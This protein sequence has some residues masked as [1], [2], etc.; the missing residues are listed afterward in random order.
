MAENDISKFRENGWIFLHGVLNTED[1]LLADQEIKN[2][3]KK[4]S[5]TTK[6]DYSKDY[7]NAF[8]N[9][10]DLAKKSSS[11]RDLVDKKIK[12]L[13]DRL[14]C[15]RQT[16]YVRDQFFNKA[17]ETRHTPLH[18]DAYSLPYYCNN[19]YTLWIPLVQVKSHPLLLLDRSHCHKKPHIRPEKDRQMKYSQSSTIGLKP[20]DVSVHDGWL[21][22][23]T[24]PNTVV[25]NQKRSAW[26]IIFADEDEL[27]HKKEHI[28]D[29]QV[30]EIDPDFLKVIKRT[31][32]EIATR[33]Y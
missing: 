32:N 1:I 6:S 29:S 33:I 19:V 12:P 8:I 24:K 2:I 20:G 9:G 31:R 13:A 10:I 16:K 7:S 23:G 18:Q 11:L 5:Y 21:I 4:S 17:N 14:N 27:A 26:S 22:H 3:L 30:A 15:N 28:H 25:S